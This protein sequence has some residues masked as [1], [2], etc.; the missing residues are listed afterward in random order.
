MGTPEYSVP[1]LEAIVKAG[2]E[3]VAVYSQPPRP[4]GR[5]HKIV[6]SAVHETAEELGIPVYTPASLRSE[7]AQQQFARLQADVA[8]VVVYGLILPKAILSAPRYGCINIHASIL[9]RWRGA[10]PIQR[11][12]LAGDKDTGVTIMQMDEGLDTGDMLMQEEI[13]ITGSSTSEELHERVFQLGSQLILEILHDLENGELDPQPQPHEG[14]TYADKLG[15]DE[16]R[17][18]WTH[19]ADELERKVRA[20]NP[21]PGVWFEYHGERIKVLEAEVAHLHIDGKAGEVLDDQ[22]TVACGENSL[23]LLKVQKSGGKPVATRDFLNGTSIQI[24]DKLS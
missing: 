2:H 3:V 4:A 18:I 14:V 5:G 20:L 13:P 15:K 24:G 7:E 10:A 12:I 1:A 17:I 16:G 9:P 11:G 22:L 23:R 21:R 19:N 8:V 6:K